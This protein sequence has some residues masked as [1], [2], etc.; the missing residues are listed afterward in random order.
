MADNDLDF[1]VHP[2]AEKLQ[3]FGQGLLTPEEAATLEEHLA[4]C[5]E[6]CHHL[7]AT[8]NDSFVGQLR[9]AQD[10][11]SPDTQHFAAGYSIPA[12]ESLGGL[13][14]HPRYR[15]VRLL[16]R[17][18]MGAVY[19][20]E[21][22]RMGRLV[23][24]KIINPE[25][26]NHSGA[27]M[28]FQ[29]EVKTAA[30]LDHANIV[31]AF[32]AD[33]AGNSH[34]L[35]ME[36]VEGQNLSD[37]LA[38][39]GPL[40][41][42]YACDII[43]QAA[44]GLQ[45]AH[46]RGMVHRDI[47]PHN[48]MLTPPGQVK[49]LDFG[50]A[51]FATEAA[52][53]TK[54][55]QGATDSHLT[56]AGAVMGTADYIAPEQAR[57]AHLADGRSDVYSL[58]CTLYHLLSGQPP[59]PTG[60]TREKLQ[61]HSTNFPL[62]L[63]DVR[64]E[65]PEGLARV[66][67][68]MMAKKPE[69]RFHTAVEVAAALKPHA[70]NIRAKR[71]KL[72]RALVAFGVLA[73]VAASLVGAVSMFWP[74][75]ERTE[76]I[77]V[78]VRGELA[79][80]KEFE[81]QTIHTDNL[82]VHTVAIS[83]NEK[84]VAAAGGAWRHGAGWKHGTDYDVRL[85]D[86]DTGK[87]LRRL[88]GL[89]NIVF[90]VAF[91]PDGQWIAAT[92]HGDANVYL[93]DVNDGKLLRTFVGHNRQAL[94]FAFSSDSQRLVTTSWD[95]T[96]RLWDTGTGLEIRRVGKEL[97]D[98]W[99]AAVFLPGDKE[100]AI[101]G[102][103]RLA[104]FNVE[105]GAVVRE[106]PWQY[107]R[108]FD[109]AVSP[110]GTRLLT[111]GTDNSDGRPRLWEIATGKLI[112]TFD[113]LPAGDAM[114]LPNLPSPCAVGVAFLP[115]G[116]RFLTAEGQVSCLRSLDTSAVLH[117]FDGHADCVMAIAVSS[118]GRYAVSGGLDQK[119][120]VW[121]LPDPS[122]AVKA[123]KLAPKI[124][125]PLQ[126]IHTDNLPV[127]ALAISPNEKL[128]A[129]A[130]GAWRHGATWKSG[131]D[132]DVRLFE[133][134]TGKELRR[135]KGP[136]STVHAVAFSPDGAWITAAGGGDKNAYLW[137]VND[138]K[139][140]RTF[141]GHTQP[142]IGVTFSSDGKQLLT[143]GWDNTIR[144]WDTG[145]GLEIR[146]LGQDFPIGWST[147]VFLPGEKQAVVGGWATLAIVDVGTG[148]TV[149]VLP[150]PGGRMWNMTVSPSGTQLLTGGG[151]ATDGRIRLWHLPSGK[152]IKAF[153]T[154]PAGTALP[155]PNTPA[156]A[157]HGVAFLP[158]GKR[159]L[160]AEGNVSR[161]RDADTGK[162]L[163]TFDGHADCVMAVAVSSKGRFAV[164]G[165]LDQKVRV[166]RLPDPHLPDRA[167]TPIFNGID[168]T[169]WHGLPGHWK[170]RD[171]AIIGAPANG[172]KAHTFLCSQKPYQD[173]ELQF[174]V[175]RKNGVGNTGVQFRSTLTDASRF[176]VV[177][178]QIEIDSATFRYPPGSIVTEPTAK[179]FV[180]SDAAAMAKVWKEAD[181]N[182]M[183]IRCV[184]KHVTVSVNGV[185]A[186]DV[187]FPSLPD[188]GII[189]W[190]LHGGGS[191]GLDAPEEV[192]FKDIQFTDLTKRRTDGFVPLFNGKD[193]RGWKTHPDNP[194]DW[195]IE[196]GVLVGRGPKKNYLYSERGDYADFHFRIEAM[197]NE[198][199]NSGQMFRK[200]FSAEHFGNGYEAQIDS[201]NHEFKTGSLF[202][203]GGVPIVLVNEVLVPPDTWFTQEVIARGNHITILVNGSKVAGYIDHEWTWRSGHLA[204]QLWEPETVVRFR[205]IE[206]KELATPAGDGKAKNTHNGA[207][208][209]PPVIGF[210]NR[211]H[212]NPIPAPTPAGPALPV[213]GPGPKKLT[214]EEQR[215][216][217]FWHD[218]GKNNAAPPPF[219]KSWA[220]WPF[221]VALPPG[222]MK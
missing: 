113:N 173:F 111:V 204:L 199:G 80:K 107:G 56:G 176:T 71:G 17:G 221:P 203:K 77:E 104:I 75:P 182:D 192:V 88:K 81:L 85:F 166:W 151:D 195:R 124:G 6:C 15:V 212:P 54:V 62:W 73:V 55:E 67:A 218:Y 109:L 78:P 198:K 63:C 26:L 59:F 132:W 102:W 30:K 23:A 165:G 16:G 209:E 42:A 22:R 87:E 39:N 211:L 143:A 171:G 60:T 21:H 125:L 18:G 33:Q 4:V 95:N 58:G 79:P 206:I 32:D 24:L 38:E 127:H 36:Y 10:L 190:Q 169:G 135:L 174:K 191:P 205:K 110:D 200:A 19:L 207:G 168:L 48:L 8:P 185:V 114:P 158:D 156:G 51:R 121:R 5:D 72:P 74:A 116:K 183:T 25:L 20:A 187:D 162:V 115:D 66:V 12:D 41:V 189:A 122:E 2:D 150:W 65:I 220:P 96:N 46:E 50:L 9:E 219:M 14:D 196:D 35:V 180:K 99:G 13:A 175:R 167:E 120:R 117:T 178:P 98:G 155:L 126:T 119:V 184:G 34:F 194:G 160:T 179:P 201:G 76:D 31:A 97:V 123:E 147:A 154:V 89:S 61:L 193:L 101:G 216:Q 92:A 144:L 170:V 28:R 83:P 140:L 1:N 186:V 70:V 152:L 106:L 208:P 222:P 7:E 112:Q 217:D 164:S 11:P 157:A 53:P 94:R 197:I 138:G 146:R 177:G 103:N 142:V 52:S 133:R 90:A 45:H 130:G 43:R 134:E 64:P 188:E 172:V 153:D 137:N 202:V 181:F 108:V 129:A 159:C 131:T 37:Y 57:D 145:T 161:I 214:P 84:L 91:S 136:T 163:H 3:G 27:L 141:V 47:K 86:R 93:W 82:P 213:I 128:V 68:K 139:L 44:L 49:V 29:Q 100:V 149:R 118:K 148:A 105:T 69:D 210:G 215:L 40:P